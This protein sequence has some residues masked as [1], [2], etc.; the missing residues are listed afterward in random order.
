MPRNGM[1]SADSAHEAEVGGR[2]RDPLL[3]EVGGQARH[4]PARRW[5]PLRI[6]AS[7]GHGHDLL[8][9]GRRDPA[10]S[11]APYSGRRESKPRL[12]KRWITLGTWESPVI[13]MWPILGGLRFVAAASRM[14]ALGG[15]ARS[16][17]P[18]WTGA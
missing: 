7:T 9:L 15:A 1:A 12:L 13:H 2:D 6:G 17:L 10:S 11:P 8:A 14:P 18:A 3:G 16:A 5:N 4:R